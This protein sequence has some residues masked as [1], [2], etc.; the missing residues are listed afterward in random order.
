MKKN[1]HRNIYLCI[2]G[3]RK[4]K[5]RDKYFDLETS[6]QNSN[7][8]VQGE[9]DKGNLNATVLTQTNKRY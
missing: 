6:V 4:V 3:T 5:L 1:N 2:K 8:R 7:M 9:G